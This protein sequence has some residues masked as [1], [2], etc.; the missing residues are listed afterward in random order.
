VT[1]YKNDDIMNYKLS[2]FFLFFSVVVYGQHVSVVDINE[3]GVPA[4]EP[5]AFDFIHRDYELSNENLIATLQGI[6]TDSEKADLS[7]LFNAFWDKANELG[8]NSF[9]WKRGLRIGDTIEVEISIYNLNDVEFGKMAALY[10]S[11]MVYILGDISKKQKTR[12]IKFNGDK[13][14]LGPMEYIAY[15]NQVGEEAI[16]KIGGLLGAKVCIGG[17]ENRPPSFYSLSSFGVGPNRQG[18]VGLSLNTGRIYPTP[19]NFGY[20]LLPLLSERR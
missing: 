3:R 8:A 18:Q 5:K 2:V 14:R 1:P 4:S 10:P 15:Q 17:K 19:L 16:L 13:I 6:V 9:R 7:D 11:N 12:K 20:F